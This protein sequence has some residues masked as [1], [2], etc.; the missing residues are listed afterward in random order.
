MKELSAAVSA[1]LILSVILLNLAMTSMAIACSHQT[2]VKVMSRNLYIGGDIFKVF[3]AAIDPEAGPLDVPLALAQLYEIIVYTNFAERAEAIAEEIRKNRPHLIGLQE[4]STILK[5]SP[6]D[7]LLGNPQPATDIRYDYL[8]ILLAVLKKRHL[9][10]EVAVTSANADVELPMLTGFTPKGDP[11]LDDV[12][13]IDHDVILVRKDVKYWNTLA[14]NYTTNVSIPMGDLSLE[15]TRGF[16]AL[17]AQIKNEVYRFVNTHLEV[18]GGTD[19][20]FSAVQAAQMQELLTLLAYEQKPIILVGDLNSDPN[21]GALQSE[22][23]GMIY[24]AYLQAI[25]AGYLDIWTLKK[26]PAELTCCFNETVDDPYAPL[27][28]RID[29]ILIHS[30]HG[31]K[32]EKAKVKATGDQI[33]DMTVNGFWP[34]DH[35][36]LFGQIKFK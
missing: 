33:H 10:Y 27:Y 23:Y 12:R 3:E 1:T 16:T 31:L 18:A 20:A 29:H 19:H 22:I 7:F 17:D 15:F 24:P 35:A 6:G 4:V 13:L 30:T 5:Q 25:S 32:T 11:V 14:R 9:N 34:S 8:S 28:E 26:K 36:G 21:D 2:N